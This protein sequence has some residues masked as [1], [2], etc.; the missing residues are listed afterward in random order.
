MREISLEILIKDAK[1]LSR[2]ADKISEQITIKNNDVRGIMI[3]ALYSK[4]VNGFHSICILCES[5]YSVEAEVVLRT[6]LE[7][8]FFMGA[9]HNSDEAFDRYVGKSI[10]DLKK[11]CNIVEAKPYIYSEDIQEGIRNI[12]S[13]ALK[14]AGNK[15]TKPINAEEAA[16]FCSI[17]GIYE[18]AYRELS[19]PVHS[20]PG[21]IFRNYLRFDSSGIPSI[22]I[23]PIE[24]KQETVL[25]TANAALLISIEWFIELNGLE[26]NSEVDR[27]TT[28]YKKSTSITQ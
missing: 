23:G 10:T 17:E 28:K 1:D 27:I 2:L 18:Y 14:E 11:T 9:C 15:K 13:E 3:C 24:S 7:S 26:R 6:L 25:F 16:K 20:S 22:N 19:K 12:Y 4:I 8:L 21:Y 5:N